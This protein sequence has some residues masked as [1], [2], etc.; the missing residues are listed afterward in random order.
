MANQ[1]DRDALLAFVAD[2]YF[3]GELRQSDIAEEIG[4]TR[5]AVSRMLT[6]AREKGIVEVIVHY[7]IQYNHELEAE[8]K[9]LL[10]LEH[11]S[12][13][14]INNQNDFGDLKRKLGKAAFRL[15]SRLIKPGDQ[16]GVS[17][18][19]T[20]Q[21]TIEAFESTTI[22]NTKVVQLV[23]VLGSTR[24]SYSAQI[25][26]EHLAEKIGG[27]G[28]YLYSPFIVENERTAASLLDDPSVEK[29]INRGEQ[30]DI[31]LL[32]IGTTNPEFCSLFQGDHI[33][34]QELDAL[35]QTGAVGDVCAIYF[36]ITGALAL[37]DFHQRRIGVSPEGLRK[38]PIRLGVGGS[39]EKAQAIFGA[40]CGGYINSLV[41]D[42]STADLILDLARE[43]CQDR[44]NHQ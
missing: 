20:V 37:T 30:S 31:A 15:L 21:A 3:L 38:I 33:S 42:S 27:E 5:S 12:V 9:A 10:S 24:H 8:L 35:R 16:I 19:T 26:V 18:G 44:G 41:T 29:S 34:K 39:P 28:T 4:V 36:E 11:V 13:L 14:D 43:H 25:L 7:P 32:G 22:P 40:A 6:E 1:T 2:K 17:W 23:G